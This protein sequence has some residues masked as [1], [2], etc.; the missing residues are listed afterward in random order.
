MANSD[1]V[2]NFDDP[3]QVADLAQ[4]EGP[5]GLLRLAD[6]FESTGQQ[7]PSTVRTAIAMSRGPGAFPVKMNGLTK[8]TP[9][10]LPPMAPGELEYFESNPNAEMRANGQVYDSKTGALLAK[11]MREVVAQGDAPPPSFLRQSIVPDYGSPAGSAAGSLASSVSA[12]RPAKKDE[13][14]L[15]EQEVQDEASAF[16]ITPEQMRS[17]LA[18]ERS[19]KQQGARPAPSAARP[20]PAR[21]AAASSVAQGPVPS[22]TLEDIPSGPIPSFTLEDVAQGPTPEAI[23]KIARRNVSLA[24]PIPTASAPPTRDAIAPVVS[25]QPPV[26][27]T[28]PAG[29]PDSSG[30]DG[31]VSPPS[32]G[33]GGDADE[34]RNLYLAR[35][36]ARNAASFGAMGAGKSI[37]T[38][39]VEALGERLKQVQALRAK[40][41]ERQEGLA[42]ER[43]QNEQTLNAYQAQFPELREALEPLRGQTGKP[44]FPSLLRDVVAARKAKTGERALDLREQAMQDTAGYR[45]GV[46][47][48]RRDIAEDNK[49]WRAVQAGLKKAELDLRQ[50][51]NERKAAGAAEPSDKERNAFQTSMKPAE[52][53]AVALRDAD[54]LNSL[55]GGML[56]TGKPPEYLSRAD[57]A[58]FNGFPLGQASRTALAQSNP[59]AFDLLTKMAEIKTIIGHEYFGSALSPAEAERQRQ[60]MDFGALDSPE[61]IAKKMK[62]YHDTLKNAASVFLRPRVVGRPLGAEWTQNALGDIVAPGG[63]FAGLLDEGKKEKATVSPKE[64]SSAQ[65]NKQVPHPRSVEALKKDPS[66]MNRQLF[67][68]H[69]GSGAAKKALGE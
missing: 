56:V 9:S 37:D 44:V 22:Y 16:G 20:A 4:R 13:Y 48:L 35:L 1:K 63:T 18:Q 27:S 60:F 64:Q 24:S 8:T 17:W 51:E 66:T 49:Q 45:A 21:R 5:E 31:M 62:N 12:A 46:L 68:E 34:E 47:D 61:S 40:R 6:Y 52:R 36:I 41:E 53:T 29:K 43:S 32:E 23:A 57:I 69:Y 65:T 58:A 54:T 25:T 39:A 26:T 50:A 67:D 3:F 42:L 15:T 11:S 28:S 33:A 14:D 10:A 30:K 55:S 38:G 2:T 19:R 59:Q 7:T